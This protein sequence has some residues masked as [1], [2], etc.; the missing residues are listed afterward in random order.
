MTTYGFSS[1]FFNVR[2]FGFT[3][4]SHLSEYRQKA[5]NWL[6]N[7][8]VTLGCNKV[9]TQF[10]PDKPL[11]RGALAEL[12]FKW[13]NGS[14]I[15]YFQDYTPNFK[16]IKNQPKNRIRAINW[17]MYSGYSLGCNKGGTKYC[18]NNIVNRGSIAEILARVGADLSD[19]GENN[20]RVT[21]ETTKCSETWYYEQEGMSSKKKEVKKGCK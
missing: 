21:V 7:T 6:A 1:S 9:K 18:P 13:N 20:P 16:D 15:K 19:R 10:C 14:G 3:D 17:M 8:G 2:P 5:I 12:M 4:I 11:T